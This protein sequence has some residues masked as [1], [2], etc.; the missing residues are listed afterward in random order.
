MAV[1]R[2]QAGCT[3]RVLN[4]ALLARGLS[5]ASLPMLLD[6][7]VGGAVATGSHGSSL[8]HGTLSDYVLKMK[9]IAGESCRIGA[10]GIVCCEIFSAD[11]QSHRLP[12]L[13]QC[14]PACLRACVIP[15]SNNVTF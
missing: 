9:V 13:F 15:S 3:L 6:Q 5:L 7:T 12:S 10:H 1:V 4:S 11:L 8:K 14:E 2:V